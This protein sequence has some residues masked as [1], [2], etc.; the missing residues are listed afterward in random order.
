MKIDYKLVRNLQVGDVFILSSLVQT[1]LFLRDE[2]T[3]IKLIICLRDNQ[4][5]SSAFFQDGLVR[6]FT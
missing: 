5:I 6:C 3:S 2:S 1:V 4:I